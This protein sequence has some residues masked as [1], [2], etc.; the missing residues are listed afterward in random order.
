ME[1]YDFTMRARMH[2]QFVD[3]TEAWQYDGAY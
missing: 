2:L 1:F 3:T